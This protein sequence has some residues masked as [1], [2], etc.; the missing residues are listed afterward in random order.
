MDISLLITGAM[1]L[2]TPLLKKAGEEAAKTIGEKVAEKTVE[3]SF[4][5]KI[6]G[7][8]IIEDEKA[9]IEAIE[10]KP[11]ATSKDIEIIEKKLTKHINSDPQFAADLQASF[12]LST[13]NMFIAEQLLISI[14]R[15]R[16]KLVEL[17][18]ER[19]NAGIETEGSYDNMISRTSRRLSKDETKF[20]QL[21]KI[22]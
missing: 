13:T 3:K 6:K 14:K 7:I 12:E 8:F 19:S 1:T 10:N 22:N 15:D 2:L 20:L 18:D 4:W 17:F 11:I 21:M 5:K 9:I 16:Q